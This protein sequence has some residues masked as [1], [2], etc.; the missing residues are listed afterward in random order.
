MKNRLILFARR[1]A[2]AACLCA[3]GALFLG[4][5][6]A[7]SRHIAVLAKWEFAP[8]LL[9]G[10]F[11]VAAA[12]VVVTALFGRVYCGVCCPLGVLQDAAYALNRRKA[13]GTGCKRLQTVVRY[14]A[15]AAFIAAGFAGLGFSWIEPYGIF[16]RGVAAATLDMPLWAKAAQIGLLAAIFVLAVWK[17]RAW[18]NWICPVG[19]FLGGLS[20][21]ALFT[22][23]I[24][25]SKCVGCRKCER[26][27]RAG[28]IEISA[29][30]GEGGAIDRTRCV[31]CRDCTVL[32]PKG[33]IYSRPF[34]ANGAAAPAPA[35]A[36]D[37]DGAGKAN[38][39]GVTRRGFI[40]GTA[41]LGAA[42]AADAA[43]EKIH[44]G[45]LAPVTAPGIDKREISLKPAGSHSLKNFRT[46]CVGCQ[47]CVKRCPNKV[48]RPSMRLSDFMQPEMAFDKGFCTLDCTE[49]SRVCPAGAIEPV[50][51]AMK[52]NIHLGAAVWHAERCLASTQGVKCKACFRHCPV[53]AI[54][55][56][57][58]SNGN[59]VPVVDQ[60][61]CIGCGACEHVC[62]V[63]PYPAMTVKAFERHR[64][65]WPAGGDAAADEARRLIEREGYACVVIKDGA[66]VE[67]V[68]GRGV[69]PLLSLYDEKPEVL[70]GAVVVDKVVGRAAAAIA[71]AGG[72][73]GV[74]GLTVSE[75]A[76]ALLVACKIECT[77][78]AKVPRILDRERAGLCPLENACLDAS[79][80][81]E[82]VERLRAFVAK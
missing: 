79:A 43:E 1:L 70:R 3:F 53:K 38:G 16:G 8:S 81:A 82:I 7:L 58:D 29:V 2:A 12:A 72:A 57:A 18:C 39:D 40:V 62:P 32:C 64:E 44:D 35:P 23:K 36:D 37:A 10:N 28:A 27:C 34:A 21:H 51:V 31:Q 42:F 59:L 11:A 78:I 61:K 66:I 76:Q 22:P 69:M 50:P 56:I 77:A 47:L 48:L 4:L 75:E 33:A 25:A 19:T 52:P 74:I 67:R 17:G 5:G 30:R 46:R 41:A 60:D 63:R 73:S 55:R 68:R 65:V 24:D 49:C 26:A 80:P 15:M 13:Q 14:V 45:G 20:R 71:A 9:A 6:G 54:V